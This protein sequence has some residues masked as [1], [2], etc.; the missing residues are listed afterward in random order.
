MTLPQLVPTMQ[1]IPLLLSHPGCHFSPCWLLNKHRTSNYIVCC[2]KTTTAQATTLRGGGDLVRLLSRAVIIFHRH[3][4][5]SRPRYHLP[6]PCYPVII[7]NT[8]CSY[9]SLPPSLH[10][11]HEALSALFH[12]QL[13]VLKLLETHGTP[14][15]ISRSALCSI[16]LNEIRKTGYTCI[17]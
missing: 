17:L 8:I 10:I 2:V 3:R 11:G 6:H 15:G 1:F 16:F 5:F 9:S 4:S 7:I 13:P 12:L 14:N